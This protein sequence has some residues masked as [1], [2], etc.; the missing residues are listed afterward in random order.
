MATKTL[1]LTIFDQGERVNHFTGPSALLL[2]FYG[3]AGHFTCGTVAE[4][5]RFNWFKKSFGIN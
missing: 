1:L 5:R 3:Q 4:Q 2:T